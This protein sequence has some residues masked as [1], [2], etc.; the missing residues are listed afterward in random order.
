MGERYLIPTLYTRMSV[1]LTTP[2]QKSVSIDTSGDGVNL[3]DCTDL[4]NRLKIERVS[5]PSKLSVFF[6]TIFGRIKGVRE[7][8]PLAPVQLIAL[9]QNCDARRLPGWV[10]PFLDAPTCEDVPTFGDMPSQIPPEV[11]AL[12]RLRFWLRGM[13][14]QMRGKQ[15]FGVWE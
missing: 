5:M 1:R 10:N 3:T 9:S 14:V 4:C 6:S 15:A 2:T 8:A 13:P 12:Y 11:T 7:N